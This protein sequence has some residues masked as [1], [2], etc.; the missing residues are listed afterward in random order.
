MKKI[1]FGLIV[2]GLTTHMFSQEITLD[3]IQ[4]FSNHNYFTASNTEQLALPVKKLEDKVVDYKAEKSDYKYSKGEIYNVTFSIPEGKIV[5]AY[6]DD[7][8]LISTIEKYS[9][10]R[11]PSEVIYSILN[12]FPNWAIISNTYYVNF[13]NEKGIT[14]KL[15]KIELTNADKSL[16]I[17]TDEKGKFI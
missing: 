9:N 2:L 16:D 3:E 8:K 15:Y 13:H 1:A 4:L 17:K 10:V 12:R 11:L 6:D 5:A 7:G 14:K